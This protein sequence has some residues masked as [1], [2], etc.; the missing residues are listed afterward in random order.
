MRI[1]YMCTR[2]TDAIQQI[3]RIAVMQF[4]NC[5]LFLLLLEYCPRGI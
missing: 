4:N 5:F 2:L 1:A 3:P